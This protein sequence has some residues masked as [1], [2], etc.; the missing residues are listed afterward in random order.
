MHGSFG[1]AMEE[2][3][4]LMSGSISRM[5]EK[6][7]DITS[8]GFVCA[9]EGYCKIDKRNRDLKRSRAETQIGCPVHIS[10]KLIRETQEYQVHDFHGDHN[11][12]LQRPEATHLM[13]S[14]CEILEPY[15]VAINL[16]DEEKENEIRGG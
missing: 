5:K 10:L 15:G 12:D 8:R 2:I 3:F 16:A 7:G 1:L 9:N 13:P 11:H 4:F 14:Q 6:K